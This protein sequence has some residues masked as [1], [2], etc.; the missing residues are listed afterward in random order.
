MDPRKSPWQLVALLVLTMAHNC[1][2]FEFTILHM[3]CNRNP[4]QG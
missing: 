2:G 3:V 4:A 1:L